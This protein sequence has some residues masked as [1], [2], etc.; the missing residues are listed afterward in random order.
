MHCMHKCCSGWDKFRTF[1]VFRG[2]QQVG[3]TLIIINISRSMLMETAQSISLSSWQWWH[4]KWR[5]QTGIPDDPDLRTKWGFVKKIFLY[6]WIKFSG[7]DLIYWM[8]GFLLIIIMIIYRTFKVT[9]RYFK[10]S[11]QEGF[12]QLTKLPSNV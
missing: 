5:I 7:V 9:K 2:L 3:Q 1:L 12:F 6:P 8:I 10:S 11:C 4:G